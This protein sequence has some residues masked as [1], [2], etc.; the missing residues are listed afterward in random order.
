MPAQSNLIYGMPF[1][2]IPDDVAE[3]IKK[4]Y[5]EEGEVNFNVI[6][7][8]AYKNVVAD[9]ERQGLLHVVIHPK[10][11][12]RYGDFQ[13]EVHMEGEADET[14]DDAWIGVALTSRYSPVLADTSPSGG[15]WPFRFDNRMTRIQQI[16]AFVI[17][18]HAPDW[19]KGEW[20]VKEA[21]Y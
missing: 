6:P 15:C 13:F 11:K 10:K 16:A 20:I 9:C 8:E 18:E 21:W 12:E 19:F 17:N 14:W 5:D 7:F 2:D 3:N 1:T 4:E